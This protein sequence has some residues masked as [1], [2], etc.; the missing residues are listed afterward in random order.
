MMEVRWKYDGSKVE[1]GG[2]DGS[3][4]EVGWK[5]N[6]SGGITMEGS[7][8]NQPPYNTDFFHFGVTKVSP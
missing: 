8:P 3:T 2:Y 4:M 5:Y 6:G 1:M 7:G